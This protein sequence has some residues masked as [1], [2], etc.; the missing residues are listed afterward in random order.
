MKYIIDMEKRPIYIQLY[1]QIRDDI[2]NGV[3]S[4]NSKLPSKRGLAEETGVST[5]TVE[6]A[7]ELLCDEGYVEGKAR[8]GYIVM[9]RKTDGFAAPSELENTCRLVYH[10]EHSSYDFPLSV[11]SKT[12]RKVL[13]EYGALAL[14]KSPNFKPIECKKP[15]IVSIIGL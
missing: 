3:Y 13:S 1:K 8:S 5:I 15:L 11:L 10:T 6:H 12:M 9:F 2:I 7:Y 14:E 4:Y